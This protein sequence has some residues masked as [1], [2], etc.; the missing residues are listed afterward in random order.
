MNIIIRVVGILADYVINN[1]E[2]LKNIWN[3][4]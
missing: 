1:I 4:S 2:L 3:A